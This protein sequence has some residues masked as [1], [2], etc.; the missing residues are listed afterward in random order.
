MFGK[1]GGDKVA[2]YWICQ[3]S[4]EKSVT[5]SEIIVWKKD[6][7]NRFPLANTAARRMETGSCLGAPL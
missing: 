5:R 4:M 2:D 3:V 1:G 7:V 6:F